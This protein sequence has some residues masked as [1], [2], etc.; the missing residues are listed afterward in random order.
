MIKDQVT[1]A[2][3]RDGRVNIMVATT[4]NLVR[5]AQQRH[6]L[7]P[8]SS[9]ALGRV[10]SMATIMGTQL[11]DDQSTLAITVHGDGEIKKISVEAKANG[12]VR[13]YV[14]N[15][16]VLLIKED[17]KK[18][19]VGKA[20]GKGTLTV[21]RNYGLKSEYS[22]TIDLVSG[23]IGEDFAYYYYQSEQ[24]PSAVSVGVLVNEMGEVES[25][26]ALLIQLLPDHIED[27]I[28]VVEDIIKH[29]K[30]MSTLVKEGYTSEGLIES[31]F[32]DVSAQ[33]TTDAH[34]GCDC[35]QHSM[36]K[37]LLTLSVDELKTM[38]DEDQGITLECHFCSDD[39][40]F[41]VEAIDRIISQIEIK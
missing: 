3:V 30:P 1:R 7:Y 38:R 35:D 19:D 12:K 27:D 9:A 23:E 10:L 24:I 40:F 21:A 4:T 26:G 8:T 31:L 6:Q 18:L 36:E 13:G 2:L 33:V 14:D 41:D 16:E 15:K 34:F 22:S 17:Q 11:K 32:D 28:I 20:V 25:A 39:Y 37:I 5:E 29:L